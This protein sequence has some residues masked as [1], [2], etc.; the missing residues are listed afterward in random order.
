MTFNSKF[1]YQ[2]IQSNPAGH[3]MLI[4][5]KKVT[6]MLVYEKTCSLT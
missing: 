4:Y 3:N 6:I 1:S 2:N 5:N